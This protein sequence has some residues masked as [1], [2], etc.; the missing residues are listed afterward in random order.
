MSA[1]EPVGPKGAREKMTQAEAKKLAASGWWRGKTA[2]EIADFQLREPMLCM[3]FSD[4]HKAVTEALGR[5][6]YTH[7][8][9]KPEWLIDELEGKREPLD[10]FDSLR[11]IAGPDKPVVVI[12][13]DHGEQQ[14]DLCGKVAE[15]RPYGPNGEAICF[16]CSMKDKKTTE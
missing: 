15:L 14:C 5:P 3:D 16:E 4:F 10:V 13:G 7:E 9:A 12:G 6:V 2:R 11:A 8:F 1:G